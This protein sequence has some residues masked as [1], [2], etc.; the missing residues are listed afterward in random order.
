[1]LADRVVLVTG[2][3]GGLGRGIAEVCL[4]EGAR[5]L[6]LDRDEAAVQRAAGELGAAAA[7]VAG[8]VTREA[9]L[10]RAI[11]E[12]VRRWGRID[13]LVNNAGVNFGA[14]FLETSQ[15]DWARVIGINLTPVFSLTRKVIARMVEQSPAGGSIVNISSV[16]A[17]AT[18]PGAGPYAATKAAIV[19]LSQAV[20]LE[21]ATR[22]I[23]VNVVSPGLCD[24]AIWKATLDAAKDR[25]ACEAHWFSNIPIERALAP[26]EIGEVVA[27][28][29][30]QRSSAITGSN[31]IADGGVLANLLS[32]AS[33]E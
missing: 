16:H 29:L 1:M 14:P 31:I 10:D 7:A 26:A 32:K 24:T 13:G 22:R 2:A 5:C 17:A 28:L 21:F 12:C 33:H 8:D 9:D 30:S 11:Q 18:V 27:F 23:R 25:S 19:S 4:R 20:A 6:L 3:A 15:E